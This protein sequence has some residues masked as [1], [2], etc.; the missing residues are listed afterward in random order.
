M[1]MLDAVVRH[2]DGRIYVD[3]DDQALPAPDLKGLDEGREVTVGV[4]PVHLSPGESGLPCRISVVEP[5]GAET[6]IVVHGLGQDLT[7]VLRERG[8]FR[9]GQSIHLTADPSAMHFFDRDSGQ[10]IT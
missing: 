7:A 6:H 5:T 8:D 2:R 3:V 10:R 4:R 1:N 9:P